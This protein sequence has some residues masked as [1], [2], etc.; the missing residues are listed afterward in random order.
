MNPELKKSLDD[1][2]RIGWSCKLRERIDLPQEILDRYG[3]I[4]NDVISSISELHEA[5]N[6]ENTLWLLTPE[7]YRLESDSSFAWNEWEI[8]SLESAKSDKSWTADIKNFWD[9][10]FPIALSVADGYAY[11]AIVRDGSVVFGQGPD[12]EGVIPF[13]DSYDDF[14]AKLS[15]AT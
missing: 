10:H 8:I 4:H 14:I 6:P 12:F 7:D 1:L 15:I 11:Y 5:I 9:N 13:A 3:W 2:R